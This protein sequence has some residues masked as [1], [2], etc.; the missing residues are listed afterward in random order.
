MTDP[1]SSSRTDDPEPA[2]S[3]GDG[4]TEG[5]DAASAASTGGSGA[6]T[7]GTEAN[8][9]PVGPRIVDGPSGREIVVPLAVYKRVTVFST[10]SAVALVVLGFVILDSATNR[11]QAVSLSR[12]DLLLALL[13]V[14][15][16]VG[17]A[18][19]YAFSTRFRTPGMGR[20]K[21]DSD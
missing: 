3:A 21:G 12:V 16:I 15:S 14:G 10:I 6:D 9:S 11:A 4:S 5:D 8:V 13:G 17:G 2:A 18:A 7:E 1:D 20:S 19:I